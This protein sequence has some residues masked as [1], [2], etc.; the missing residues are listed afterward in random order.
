MLMYRMHNKEI[1]EIDSM[2]MTNVH[3]YDT[4]QKYHHVN[5]FY[6]IR[7]YLQYNGVLEI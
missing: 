2:F 1:T 5:G 3:K 7:I 4:L 6:I